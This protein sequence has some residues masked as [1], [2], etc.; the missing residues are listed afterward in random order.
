MD[1][2]FLYIVLHLRPIKSSKPRLQSVDAGVMVMAWGAMVTLAS[3]L[4]WITRKTSNVDDDRAAT[5]LGYMW[6]TSL[7]RPDP[8]LATVFSPMDG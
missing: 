1:S 4:G 3:E 6:F 5:V 2:F 8:F 7:D